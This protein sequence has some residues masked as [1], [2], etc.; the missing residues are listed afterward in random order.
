MTTESQAAVPAA[1][2][3]LDFTSYVIENYSSDP[4]VVDRAAHALGLAR[5]AG[6]PVFHVVPEALLA[7]I[8]PLLA[9]QDGEPVLGKTTIGAFA[10]TSLHDLLQSQGIGEVVLA[11]VATSGTVLSSARWAADVGYRVVVCRDACADPDPGAHA[12]LVDPDVFPQSWLGLWRIA[13]VLT[14]ADV[15]QLA[16]RP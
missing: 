14:T 9:P 3:A 5:G 16:P 15:P 1:F 6:L 12:A 7:D 2:V 10:T 13:T 4:A 11:G 8:H